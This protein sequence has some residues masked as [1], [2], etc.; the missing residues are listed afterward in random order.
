MAREPAKPG[1]PTFLV[2]RQSGG[3]APSAPAQAHLLATK[4]HYAS[5]SSPPPR[6]AAGGGHPIDELLQ[7]VSPAL[8]AADWLAGRLEP[9]IG[10]QLVR[11]R[12]PSSVFA[13]RESV[14][15]VE[16]DEFAAREGVHVA[17]AFEMLADEVR[18]APINLAG[19]LYIQQL[20]EKSARTRQLVYAHIARNPSVAHVRV[21]SPVFVVGLPRTGSTHLQALLSADARSESLRLYEMLVP[22]PPCAPGSARARA[23]AARLGAQKRL[24]D[25]LA[26]GWNWRNDRFHH[27]LMDA[28]EEEAVLLAGCG[29]SMMPYVCLGGV[30]T[31][32]EA[33]HADA[34]SKRATFR[35]LRRFLQLASGARRGAGAGADGVECR[36]VLKSHYNALWTDALLAEFPDAKLIITVR[37]PLQVVQSFISYSIANLSF[38]AQHGDGER[39]SAARGVPRA[40][41]ARRRAMPREAR[42][43]GARPLS[44]IHI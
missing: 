25:V 3:A 10:R 28:P 31:A 40:R 38:V 18:R 24:M 21:R 7:R 33:A 27:T 13:A 41:G 43:C 2:E 9:C 14:R 42:A 17:L 39:V 8:A 37:E 15:R 11:V 30:G 36:W 20:F 5:S 26:P 19:R 6:D 29:V 32:Y 16:G 12:T 34:S 23:R 44:L 4:P 22:L 1:A 35:F